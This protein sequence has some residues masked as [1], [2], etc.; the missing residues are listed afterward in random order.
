MWYYQPMSTSNKIIINHKELKQIV[1]SLRNQKSK[2]VLTQGSFDMI[3]IGHGRYLQ[4]AKKRGHILIVGVDDDDKVRH[5]KGNNRPV[6]PQDERLE[7]LSYLSSVDYV[8]IKPHKAPKWQ[9]IKTIRPDIL[10]ATEETYSQEQIDLLHEWCT[11]VV[12]LKSQATTSTS[13]KIRRLQIGF[14]HTFSDR[15]TQ[16]VH[17]AIDEVVAELKR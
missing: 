17:Q 9:L 3:H 13:A 7:M 4:K 10:I 2:I 6:V 5:R 8:I 15:L 14:F 12:V 11:E 16:K 1:E